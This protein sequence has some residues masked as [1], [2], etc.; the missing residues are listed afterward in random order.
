MIVLARTNA[1]YRQFRML[2]FKNTDPMSPSN[3]FRTARLSPILQVALVL[4]ALAAPSEAQPVDDEV[5]SLVTLWSNATRPLLDFLDLAP[6]LDGSVILLG[7]DGASNKSL[8]FGVNASGFGPSVPLP[9]AAGAPGPELRLAAGAGQTLFVGGS[10]NH[11]MATFGGHLW[12]AYLA[13]FDPAG[14]L[15]W[16]RDFGRG[17]ERAIQSLAPLPTGD[18]IVAGK[19]D[20]KTWLARISGDGRVVWEHAFGLGSVAGVATLGDK[21]VVAA[22]DADERIAGQEGLAVWR[23]NGGGELLDH[24]IVEKVVGD[25]PGPFWFIRVVVAPSNEDFY[26]FSVWS[27]TFSRNESLSAHPLKVIKLTAEDEVVWRKELTQTVLQS[28]GAVS[29]P[30]RPEFCRPITAVLASGSALVACST[31]S[32]VVLSQ[33]DSRTGELTR[34]IAHRAPS[35]C[36]GAGRG[37]KLMMERSE[38][39]IWMFGTARTCTW[40]GQLS[41]TH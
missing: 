16:E 39:I 23:F 27:E 32:A 7:E 17:S 14:N 3:A 29:S 9:G 28:A 15:E 10:R 20:D 11:R 38:S 35:A 31:T 24:R 37:A 13:K 18:V 2:G 33:L 8:L 22:F 5:K 19:D 25:R 21:I 6:S 30:T 41:L 36:E 40:L 4:L 12:D 34:T 1:G 26:V